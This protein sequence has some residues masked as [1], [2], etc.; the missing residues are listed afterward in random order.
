MKITYNKLVRD[1]IPEIISK[2][3]KEF[4]IEKISEQNF[5]ISLFDKLREEVSELVEAEGKD[6]VK[7][8]GDIYEVLDSITKYFEIS[9]QEVKDLQAKRKEERGGFND[10]IRLLWVKEKTK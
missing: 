3:G 6:R 2:S 7:E 4:A 10:Q 9:N 5:L 8:L 1:R